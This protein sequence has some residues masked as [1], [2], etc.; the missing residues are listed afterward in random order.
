MRGKWFPLCNVN[1]CVWIVRQEG[2]YS[3]HFSKQRMRIIR[4]NIWLDSWWMFV[5]HNRSENHCLRKNL[6]MIETLKWAWYNAIRLQQC[7]GDLLSHRGNAS[8]ESY[9][10]STSLFRAIQFRICDCVFFFIRKMIEY[11]KIQANRYSL[12]CDKFYSSVAFISHF[13]I[14]WRQCDM[15]ELKLH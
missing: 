1:V 8:C 3:R 6:Q 14:N 7:I 15:F 12:L 13:M 2:V 10:V 5:Q 9:D 11:T 4:T